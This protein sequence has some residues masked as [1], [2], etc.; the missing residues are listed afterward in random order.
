MYISVENYREM[1]LKGKDSKVVL[2]EIEKIRHEIAKIK[3][4]LESPVNSYNSY[5]HSSEIASIDVFRGYLSAALG[6][7]SEI[8]EEACDFTEEEKASMIFDST[9]DGISCITLTVGEYLQDKYELI[10]GGEEAEILE[11]HLGGES[12]SRKINTETAREK[13]HSLHIGEWHENYSPEKYGCTLNEAVKWQLR[14][15]YKTGAAPRFF[16]GYGVFPY[17]FS[18]L[19]RLLGADVF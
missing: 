9:V 8:N 19:A 2:D 14:I 5:T 18:I 13:I 1:Y 10:F 11:V 4:K 7:L 12:V 6:Y 3:N 15:D 17:N 16:D